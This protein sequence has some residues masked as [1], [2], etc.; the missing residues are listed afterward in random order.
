MERI[1]IETAAL[2][3]S[4]ETMEGLLDA[5]K[6]ELEGMYDA[7]QNLSTMWEGPAHDAFLGQFSEDRQQA[8][9][10]CS[11]LQNFIGSM[12]FAGITYDNCEK[13]ICEMIDSIR[14]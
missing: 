14:I 1:T 12:N 2:K 5:I 10:L 13:T 4:V 9:S 3:T 6:D 11:T 7:V 8:A